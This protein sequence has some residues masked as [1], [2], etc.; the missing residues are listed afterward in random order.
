MPTESNSDAGSV[1]TLACL[2]I[3]C[4][5][6]NSLAALDFCSDRRTCAEISDPTCLYFSANSIPSGVRKS[7][8]ERKSSAIIL[9][10]IFFRVIISLEMTLALGRSGSG[11]VDQARAQPNPIIACHRPCWKELTCNT[12]G[13]SFPAHSYVTSQVPVTMWALWYARRQALHENIFQSPLSTHNFIMRYI[14][15]LEDCKP[16]KSAP[17][18]APNVVQPRQRWISPPPGFAKIRV[19]GAV[20]RDNLH[21]SFSAICRDS[22]GQFLGASAIKIQGVTEPATLEALACREALAL[23]SD[24]ALSDFIVADDIKNGTGG[25]YASIVKEISETSRDFHQCTFIFEGRSTNIEA[26][27]LAKH[28]FGLDLGRHLW[29][30]NPPDIHCIPMNLFE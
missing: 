22:Y 15:E 24:L 28:A 20:S 17:H 12:I 25:T 23:A 19:D 6:A 14:R 30:I 21:G 10:E 26:H 18:S 8:L 1:H 4:R 16:K 27:S 5:C 7:H 13:V 11:L 29:L 2:L 9:L 3:A